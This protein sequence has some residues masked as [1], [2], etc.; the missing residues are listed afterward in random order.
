MIDRDKLNEKAKA[1]GI[2]RATKAWANTEREGGTPHENKTNNTFEVFAHWQAVAFKRGVDWALDSSN[3]TAPVECVTVTD[4]IAQ[5]S[6]EKL[7]T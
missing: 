4:A 5:M 1:F 2:E 6:N 3:H 7:A